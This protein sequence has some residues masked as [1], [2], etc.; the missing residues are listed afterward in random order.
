MS[1]S[2]NKKSALKVLL[3]SNMWPSD[4]NPAFGSFVKD[5]ADKIDAS[6]N[7]KLARAAISSS[8][9][10]L[11]VPFK[12]GKLLL[13]SLYLGLLKKPDIIYCHY[14]FPTGYIGNLI[15]K[16]LGTTLVI[17]CHGSDVYL[18]DRSKRMKDVMARTLGGADKII[19]VSNFLADEL[20]RRFPGVKAK[21]EIINCGVDQTLFNTVERSVDNDRRNLPVILFVGSL[22]NNKNVLNLI[23]AVSKIDKPFELKIVG[24][25]PLKEVIVSKVQELGISNK[26]T[27]TGAVIK[28]ELPQIYCAA[29]VLV[30]PSLREAFGLVALES[31]ACG[32]PVIASR[33]GG[34]AELIND[35][36]NGILVDP[37]NIDE[38]T[39]E[40]SGLL[41]DRERRRAIADRA[42]KTADE[43]SLERQ[44]IRITSL[45]Q[46]LRESQ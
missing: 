42:L 20:D 8:K 24:S 32:L 18:A 3:I 16:I 41:F 30:M 11:F 29:D 5:L 17:T 23:S 2:L 35:G 21:T 36:E 45:F 4:E 27:I 6:D 46:Q 1:L 40:I 13:S 15:K 34:L 43:N 38:I 33:T 31:M 12:Y 28:A 44:A 26:V 39:K 14:L 22:N 10:G 9:K 37:D 25:G 7:I 19:A